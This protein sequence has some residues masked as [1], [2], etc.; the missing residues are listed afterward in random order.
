MY[1]I[2]HRKVRDDLEE[3]FSDYK[4]VEV[5]KVTTEQQYRIYFMKRII[6]MRE[7]DKPDSFSKADFKYLNKNDI[8]DMP[9]LAVQASS[10]HCRPINQSLDHDLESLDHLW[11]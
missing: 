2:K 11:I 8:E 10:N 6:V 7:N 4:I 1:K 5:V 9:C 3:V